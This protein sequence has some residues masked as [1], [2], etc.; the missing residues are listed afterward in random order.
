ME[1]FGIQGTIRVSFA[2]Y[3]TREEIDSLVKGI[4]QVIT[5]FN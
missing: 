2:V 4:R 1:R 3:N 5:M